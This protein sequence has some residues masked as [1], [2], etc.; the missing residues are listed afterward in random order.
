MVSIRPVVCEK[1]AKKHYYMMKKQEILLPIQ[2]K[3]CKI[4][5]E[6]KEIDIQ[7]FQTPV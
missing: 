6:V 1:E 5:N 7:F 2:E 3:M 4:G